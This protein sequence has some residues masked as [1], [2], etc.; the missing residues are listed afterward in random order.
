MI[1]PIVTSRQVTRTR[2]SIFNMMNP[3]KVRAQGDVHGAIT[4]SSGEWAMIDT[5]S[6]RGLLNMRD[7]AAALDSDRAAEGARLKALKSVR[8]GDRA[9]FMAG[10]LVG[11]RCEVLDLTAA[12]AVTVRL[13]LFGSDHQAQAR[14]CDL[15]PLRGDV[16]KGG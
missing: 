1:A 7:R 8:A 4:L 6:M 12:G 3:S 15:V 16:P 9:L 13:R 5:G 2:G 14:V 10:P 11:Q